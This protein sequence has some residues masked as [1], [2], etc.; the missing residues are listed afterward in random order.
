MFTGVLKK[1]IRN[2]EAYP[3]PKGADLITFSRDW[4]QGLLSFVN[5]SS[6]ATC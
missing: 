2:D 6:F 4:N 3:N 5:V 1:G